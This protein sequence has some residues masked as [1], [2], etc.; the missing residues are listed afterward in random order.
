VS[1]RGTAGQSGLLI[2]LW[3]GIFAGPILWAADEVIGY[4]A[5][6]H[7]CSTG[8]EALFHLLT[9]GA[10]VGCL[11]GFVLAA[12]AWRALSGESRPSLSDGTSEWTRVMAVAGMVLSA[13][14]ALLVIATAIPKWMLSPC[15]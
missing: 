7:E 1:A 6:A 12:Q 3:T 13:A 9:I 15:A 11:G 8:S 5:T 4:S 10:L 2:R 14:F